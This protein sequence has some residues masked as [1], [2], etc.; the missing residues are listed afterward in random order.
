MQLFSGRSK[1]PER[2]SGGGGGKD[3]AEAMA[4]EKAAGV[5]ARQRNGRC[6]ALCCGASRLSVSSSASC[7]SVEYAMEQRL[8]PLQPPQPRGLSNLAHGMVQAR[9]QSMIDAAAGRSSAAS[10]PRYHGTTDTAERH[11]QRG[12]PCRCACACDCCCGQYEDGGAS[13]GPRRPCVVLVAVDRRTSD[14]REEFRRSIAEVITAKRMA[15]P[16]ELR[17]LL[18]CYV[19]VNARE[20]R[21]AILEAFHE[22]CSGLFSRKC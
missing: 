4:K 1:R 17:A 19:S 8:P 14:P 15:E 16:A 22:V 20:H 21:A 18:N 13:C 12:G 6:R 9:L 7:S 5:V 11:V 3:Q 2:K 10:R